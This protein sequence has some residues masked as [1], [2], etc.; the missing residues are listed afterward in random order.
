MHDLYELAASRLLCRRLPAALRG[1]GLGH[2]RELHGL[3]PLGHLDKISYA[4]A[5]HLGDV[6]DHLERRVAHATLQ[7]LQVAVRE[8]LACYVLLREP[9][10]PSGPAKVPPKPAQECPEIHAHTMGAP[11]TTI[12]P[13]GLASYALTRKAMRGTIRGWGSHAPRGSSA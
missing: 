13:I 9:P 10:A 1:Q 11:R 2:I 3:P 8:A 5:E 7:F 4:H 6:E 12:E